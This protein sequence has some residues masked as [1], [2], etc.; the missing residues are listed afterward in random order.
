[1][2]G[3]D[4]QLKYKFIFLT[5]I[6]FLLSPGAM[7]QAQESDSP[8]F[9]I[10]VGMP[11]IRNY[12]PDEYGANPMNWGAVRD[13]RGIV[14]AANLNGILEF[15]G[16]SWRTIETPKGA[17]VLSLDRDSAGI[18]YA[19]LFGDFGYLAPDSL[20]YMRF[21]SLLEFLDPDERDF[22]EV[23]RTHCTSAG[24]YFRTKDRIFLWSDNT[25][26]IF[27]SKLFY[28]LTSVLND[29]LYVEERG[30]GLMKTAGDSLALI[31]DS[32]RLNP[33]GFS[34]ILPYD[35]QYKLIC[36]R[37]G[38]YLFDGAGFSL[39]ASQVN[40]LLHKNTL[41]SAAALPGGKFAVGTYQTGAWVIDHRGRIVQVLNKSTGLRNDDIKHLYT[42]PNGILWMSLNS[43]LAQARAHDPV[44]FFTERQ[45]LK[46]NVVS[47]IRHDN[48]VYAA[49]SQ[50]VYYLDKMNTT[51]GHPVF[52]QVNGIT[53]QG[54]WLL[55]AGKRLLAATTGNGIYQIDG[56]KAS[57]INSERESVF[58]L[59]RSLADTN[60]IYAGLSN[61]LE[62]VQFSQ[63]KWRGTGR[64]KG[65]TE[66]IRTIVED[67]DGS[68]WLGTVFQGVLHVRL[69][70]YVSGGWNAEIERFNQTHGLPDGPVNIRAIDGDIVF[71][72][73]KGHYRFNRLENYFYPDPA[74]APELADTTRAAAW[75]EQDRFGNIFVWPENSKGKP[76]LWQAGKD[77]NGKYVLDKER[78]RPL[79]NFGIFH[80]VYTD[81]DSIIWIGT[82]GGLIRYDPRIRRQTS[83]G[84]PPLIRRVS[85]IPAN[86]SIFGGISSV[87]RKKIVL[88]FQNNSLRFEYA[89]PFFDDVTDNRYQYFLDG[90]DESW[91]D[92]TA[93][94]QKDYTNLGYGEYSFK[95]RAKNTYGKISRE[96]GFRFQILAP[97]Y[98]RWWAY[99]I[100]LVLLGAV[101]FAGQR[102]MRT[103]LIKRELA[104]A[105]LREA[106]II[107]QKNIQL[108]EKNKQLEE[109]LARLH[110]AQNAL[111]E[112]ES[113]F[114]S[115]AESAN[116]AIITADKTGNITFWNE[117][118]AQIFEYSKEEALNKPLTM[119]M[120]ERHRQAHLKGMERFY[121]TGRVSIMG[122]IVE[123]DAVKKSGEEFPIELSLAAWETYDGKYVTGIVRDITRRKAE[124]EALQ[125]TQA[126]LYQSEK[127]STLGKLS[128]GMAHELNNPVASAQRG[129]AQMRRIFVNLQ[130]ANI[131]IVK[132]NLS[133]VQKD[134][135]GNLE[136]LARERAL[137]PASI[138]AATRS[139][140]EQDLEKWL[141]SQG[142]ENAWEIAPSLIHLGYD[143][144]GIATL[145]D[146]FSARQLNA[147]INWLS[148]THM[149]YSL[150][151]E[152]DLGTD[153]IAEIVNAFRYYTYMDQGPVQKVD[154]HKD[155]DNML[156]IMKSR[157]KK[158]ISIRREYAEDLPHIE[159][160]GSELNQVWTNIV[161]NA[162]DAVGEKG[163]I[164]LRTKRDGTWVVVEIID[165]GTGIPKNIQ[166]RIFDPFFTTKKVGSGTGLGLHIC[167]N[168]VVQKHQGSINV[169]S[170]PGTTIFTV[171]LPSQLNHAV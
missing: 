123:L 76:E 73:H 144:Q 163:E 53:T 141:E 167:H 115:V 1:M 108:Q 158:E 106:E 2:A 71:A 37:K 110:T 23:W 127:M 4:K 26:K 103:Q 47:V 142:I 68:L 88:P 65:I 90:F 98:F 50:S 130:Q 125:N 113:R 43:G 41:S 45:G 132:S 122:Q 171:R 9:P 162:I 57:R 27:R 121:T 116:D 58:F 165:N 55:S 3:S 72:T 67:I 155:L 109:I 31:P 154:I 80:M 35:Q 79:T 92:W 134:T 147:I 170:Q 153:R 12:G 17:W 84:Y 87:K 24:T 96:A 93:E 102:M 69:T 42:D 99:S 6:V 33:I 119:L 86:T 52:K 66:E 101:L 150:L 36:T 34:A 128:A 104:R 105:E 118:A 135:L 63:Q 160:Y 54:F 126:Q 49:T 13:D 19:G 164:I 124:E 39:F 139:D 89:L 159:A 100:Y 169:F 46:G 91:S 120:P 140:R 22:T 166:S 161:D 15:D 7:V 117:K 75:I 131:L 20:G 151:H 40:D 146:N 59:C 111:I 152:I 148:A 112:S 81:S 145:A 11:A 61:G 30:T 83:M 70:S 38:L 32:R 77:S 138:D 94:T 10:E 21:V 156:I 97:W 157:I 143:R 14:Y 16:V 51:A 168:I 114:R 29:T 149:I 133:Q 48:T 44:S 137:Q 62:V 64:V 85:T 28:S 129:S 5:G 78:F 56:I 107:N 74:I 25:F 60:R 82:S 18:I 95:I 136:Q 8:I